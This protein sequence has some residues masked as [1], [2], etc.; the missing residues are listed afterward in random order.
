MGNTVGR[1][2]EELIQKHI[3]AMHSQNYNDVIGLNPIVTQLSETHFFQVESTRMLVTQKL[4]LKKE[5]DTRMRQIEDNFTYLKSQ[6]SLGTYPY[7]LL[8]NNVT[9]YAKTRD[10]NQKELQVGPPAICRQRL[11]STLEEKLI[12]GI[13]LSFQEKIN[14]AVQ[15]IIAGMLLHEMKYYCDFTLDFSMPISL[16]PTSCLLLTLLYIL[17][18]LLLTNLSILMRVSSMKLN[19]SSQMISA[20]IS[21]RRRWTQ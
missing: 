17:Q 18:T 3:F 4:F 7:F 1:E 16:P 19:L 11:H 10:P 2:V 8:S 6:I 13:S 14:L 21:L 20:A 9:V 12:G 5:D 15:I